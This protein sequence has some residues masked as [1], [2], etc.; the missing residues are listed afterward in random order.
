MRVTAVAFVSGL[1]FAAALGLAGMTDPQNVQA[2]LDVTGHWDPSLALV[3]MSAVAVYAIG[4]WW[5]RR[6]ARPLLEPSFQGA[7]KKRIDAPLVA[8]AAVFGLGWGASGYCPGPALVDLAEPSTN[9]VAFALAMLAG[10]LAYRAT[11]GAV[12]GKTSSATAFF[13]PTSHPR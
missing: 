6:M 13:A 9:L 5:A 12:A 8:G 4:A 1:V 11:R 3:M 10:I 7:D 2:F